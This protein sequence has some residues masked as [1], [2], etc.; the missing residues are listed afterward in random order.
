VP[1]IGP[2]TVEHLDAYLQALDTELTAG[3]VHRLD[4]A[5]APALGV[6]HDGI[7]GAV[8]TIVGGSPAAVYPPSL[9]VR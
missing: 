9:P 5:S 2:R 1:I 7:A 3:Q 4:Q 6:P 8:T